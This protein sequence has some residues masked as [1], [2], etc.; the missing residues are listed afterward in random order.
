MFIPED[1]VEEVRAATDIVEVV[2]EYVRLK[3]RGSNFIG[4]CPFHQEKT[5]SFNVNPEMGIFKCFGCGVGGN[6]FQF[7]MR[8]ENLEF[9][10]SVQMLAERAGIALPESPEEQREQSVIEGIYHALRFAGKFYYEALTQTEA[11]K[12]GLEYLLGRGFKPETIKK[13]GLGYAP[14]GW[15]QL[16]KAAVAKPIQTEVLERAGLVI[17]KRDG[18]GYY[19]RY[20]DRVVFP[21]F[22]HVGKVIGFGGRIL[23]TSTD[24]PKYINSP[25]T[26]V[27]HKSQVLYGLYQAKSAIRKREEVMLVE[28]YT[29][30]ISLHQAGIEH[31]VA[32]SGTALT[33]EQIKLIKRYAQRVLVLYDADSAGANAAMRG[34]DLLLTQGLT[35]YG[36]ELPP[37]EDP[38]SFVRENGGTGFENYIETHRKDFVEFIYQVAR[39][40]GRLETPEGQGRVTRSIVNTI[41]RMP[42]PTMHEPF[43]R[44]ASHVLGV[45]DIPLFEALAGVLREKKRGQPTAPPTPAP[46]ESAYARIEESPVESP[47][48]PPFDEAYLELGEP[49]RDPLPEEKMLIRLMLDHGVDMVEFIMGNMAFEEF[50]PG[51]VRETIEAILA[52]Y[53][54]GKIDRHRLVEGTFGERVKELVTDVVMHQHEPSKN[55][56]RRQNISVPRFNE[57]PSEAAASTMTQLK[58]DRVKEALD[59][60]KVEIF[61]AQRDKRDVRPLLEEQMALHDLQKQIEQRAFIKWNV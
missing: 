3:R 4:L 33:L 28:G 26:R 32:S 56:K 6:G 50:T 53:E 1:K 7:L 27:Y 42:D 20:R 2:G 52:L 55:W 14:S 47:P 51:A 15:D 54:Q 30:V 9:V 59:Q 8:I 37:G 29:D 24:Q 31:A 40:N 46:F 43:V 11:G 49:L 10:E 58:L 12:E 41:A 5:P 45:P 22:S 21:I 13:F 23:K 57:D 18:N 16:L 61:Q 25:E 19:D 39:R 17:A 38:D 35:V 36:L 48:A 34:I 60:L 44:R